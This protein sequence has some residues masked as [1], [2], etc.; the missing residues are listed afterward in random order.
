MNLEWKT[1]QRS[2]VKD[3]SLVSSFFNHSPGSCFLTSSET[4]VVGT[5][6]PEVLMTKLLVNIY[7]HTIANA[8]LMF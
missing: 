2:G 7:R 6:E 1:V 5:N 8:P 3:E 4:D